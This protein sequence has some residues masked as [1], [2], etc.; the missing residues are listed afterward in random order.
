VVDKGVPLMSADDTIQ[1]FI[2]ITSPHT[3][4]FYSAVCPHGRSD[5]HF[6]TTEVEALTGIEK[7]KR[8]AASH[9]EQ[10]KCVCIAKDEKDQITPLDAARQSLENWSKYGEGHGRLDEDIQLVLTALTTAEKERDQA[11]VD[12]AQAWIDVQRHGLMRAGAEAQLGRLTTVESALAKINDIRNSIIGYQN[13]GWSQHIYPLVAALEEAG[14][15]GLGYEEA[16]AGIHEEADHA[17]H[18][19]TLE[20]A[21]RALNDLFTALVQRGDGRVTIDLEYRPVVDFQQA[22]RALAVPPEKTT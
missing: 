19:A 5:K 3:G 4:L 14:I 20:Q 12:A 22:V 18:L 10:T 1:V 6:D 13:V 15:T 2:R 9:R 7:V 16:R 11:K 21:A 8:L 17:S